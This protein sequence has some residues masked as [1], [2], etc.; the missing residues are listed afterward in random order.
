MPDNSILNQLNMV[1]RK[2]PGLHRW[3]KMIRRA[4]MVKT[5]A[6]CVDLWR[7]LAPSRSFCFGPPK[8]AF[9]IYTSWRCE[10]RR[11]SRIV[12][13][14][15]GVPALPENSLM[16]ASGMLQH[17]SQPWPVFWSHHK[18]A[19]LVSPTLALVDERKR[20]CREAVYGDGCLEDDAA[21]RY[22]TLPKPVYL[23]GN[24]TSI[25]SRWATAVAWGWNR[26][27]PTFSHWL[28]DCLPRLALLKE[29]PTDTGILVPAKLADYQK[30]SLKLLGLLDR[31]RPTAERH[32]IVDDYYFSS[33]TGMIACYNP[34]AVNWLR[35]AFLPLADKSYHGPKR[36]IISRKGKTRG[37]QNE[38]E[39][40]AYF[41]KLGWSIIDTETLTFTQEIKLFAEAEAYAGIFGSGFTN[42]LWS[43]PGCKVITFVA[44]SWMDGGIEA[45]CVANHLDYHWQ[46]F[47]SD[48]AMR[49]KV[50]L[51]S[52]KEM[53]RRAGL[54]AG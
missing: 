8:G 28:Q 6:Q 50:D 34:Y 43:P 51:A 53:L 39:I 5:P 16:V 52:V 29:F 37:I 17:S 4:V 12:L 36:F 32:L 49:A 18:N 33:P 45:I 38:A 11:P 1:S 21:W 42:S 13:T 41:Q 30:E 2:W 9:S 3:L 46:A 23:K 10:N 40:N 31:V 44:D 47:P 27:V 20:L 22:L 15:Q 7:V 35:S 25:I 24:W 19:R 14:D 48:F 54:D 26:D